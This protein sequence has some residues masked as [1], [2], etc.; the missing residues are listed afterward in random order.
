[1]GIFKAYDIRGRYGTDL[2]DDTA[3][4]IGRAF[5]GF[6]RRGKPAGGLTVAVGRDLRPSSPA[7][8][9]AA[10]RGLVAAG[11]DVVEIGLCTTPMSY[12]AVG[13]YGYDGALMT[14]ASHNPAPD[15][16]F[17]LC[18]ER[19][20]A[21]SGETGIGEIERLVAAGLPAPAGPGATAAGGR[22]MR[23]AIR[24]DYIEHLMACARGGGRPLTVAIDAANGAAT[25][26]LP[27]LLPRLPHRV[28]PLFFEPDGRFPGHDPDPLREE[29]TVAL[30][31]AV[32]AG[33]A[34]LGVA[35]DGDADRAIFFDETGA[36]VGCDLVTALLARDLLAREPGARVVYDLRSSRVVRE[37]IERAG[38]VP[39]R[40]RVGH[41]FL[42]ATMRARDAVFGGELS[43]HFYF[44]EHFYADSALLA[45]LRV[46]DLVGGAGRPLSELAA[47]LRRYVATGELNFRVADPAAAIERVARG[48]AG[49][50]SDRLDG[51]S[52]ETADWWMNLRASNTEALLR[53]NLEARTRE[54]MEAGRREVAALVGE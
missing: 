27:F 12:F 3:E 2:T 22:S 50:V 21:L 30:A 4:R 31:A 15:N 26:I 41:S 38:G 5:A 40:E 32:R 49:A 52:V 25:T 20:I 13:H 16:G 51:L 1:M 28:L 47:P 53:L 14:T 23:R 9:Q 34:D 24:Q 10:M 43:G 46:L 37:E 17:K 39:V 7:L 35:F 36:R 33:R 44:R 18:R 42:K 45:F 19:A 54:A 11:A 8:A 29:N 6:L 48:Y